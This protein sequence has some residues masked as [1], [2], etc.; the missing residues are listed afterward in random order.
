MRKDIVGW[1]IWYALTYDI[2]RQH[3]KHA[4]QRL[5]KMHE[6]EKQTRSYQRHER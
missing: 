4:D 6:H 2:R 1:L 3:Q 5:Y